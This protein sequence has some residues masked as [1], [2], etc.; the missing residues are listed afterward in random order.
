MT[1]PRP[2][3]PEAEYRMRGFLRDRV[4]RT[5]Y[6]SRVIERL[7]I[8]YDRRGRALGIPAVGPVDDAEETMPEPDDFCHNGR[9]RRTCGRCQSLIDAA[10]GEPARIVPGEVIADY[11]HATTYRP[12]ELGP[13]GTR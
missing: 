4:W 9:W 1:E 11:D 3:L 10:A 5:N 6:V 12:D 8:E 13:V 7:M 2:T